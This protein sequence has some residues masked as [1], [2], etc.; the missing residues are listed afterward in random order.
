MKQAKEKKEKLVEKMITITLRKDQTEEKIQLPKGTPLYKFFPSHFPRP[1]GNPIVAAKVNHQDVDLWMELEEDCLVEP[2]DLSVYSGVK[3]YERSLVLLL[4]RAVQ[5]LYPGHRLEV[6]HSLSRGLYCEI[7]GPQ[8]IHRHMVEDLAKYMR[9]LVVHNEQ[10]QRKQ[11]SLAQARTIFKKHDRTDKLLLLKKYPGKKLTLHQCCDSIG[12]FYGRV[13]PSASY[14]R[15]FEL[16]YYPPGM[17]LRFPDKHSPNTIP[18]FDEQSHLF[19]V[20]QEHKSLA[21]ILEVNNIGEL[22]SKIAEGNISN[23]I[24]VAEAMQEKKIGQIADQIK[25]NQQNIRIVLIAGPSSSGKT[26]FSKRL[27]VQLKVNGIDTAPVSL[28]NYFLSRS[29]LR[30]E[31]NGEYDFENVEALDIPLLNDHLNKLADGEEVMMPEYDFNTGNR[32]ETSRPFSLKPGQILILE[33]IHALNPRLTPFVL[34]LQKFKI[35]ISALTVLNID[36]HNRIPTTDLRVIRRCVRDNFYRS[37][38][39]LQTL[40]RWPSVRKGENMYIFP[41]Q[42]TADMMFNSGMIYELSV[43]KPYAEPLLKK[44]PNDTDEYAEAQRL[45]TFLSYFDTIEPDKIPP[46]SILREFIGDS[47]FNY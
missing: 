24:C 33:G 35:Y 43:L 38:S 37:Y 1:S 9:K 2:I 22:N 44:V 20:F 17:I 12:S 42:N 36:S 30:R 32:K 7:V 34:E 4:I 47:A 16:F 15:N 25:E 23:L 19:R 21:Q 39:A 26:T 28:D 18:P 13:V 3:I 41:F 29:E 6:Q 8:Q 14:L 5:E 27:A 10:F 11:V 40:K 31:A 46:T 45:L